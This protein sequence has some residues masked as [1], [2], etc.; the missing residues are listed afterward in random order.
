MTLKEALVH[1]ICSF[2]EN[3]AILYGGVKDFWKV[4]CFFIVAFSAVRTKATRKKHVTFQKTLG[5]VA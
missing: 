1:E 3:T 4:A 5:G 2:Y